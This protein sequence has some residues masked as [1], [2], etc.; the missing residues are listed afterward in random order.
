VNRRKNGKSPS[1]FNLRAAGRPRIAWEHRDY[2]PHRTRLEIPKGKP[3]HVVWRVN[4]HVPP[5]RRSPVLKV[6]R[7]AVLKARQWGLR[8]VH[9]SLMNDHLHLLIEAENKKDLGKSLQ[10]FAISF[11]KRLK[12][13][14]QLRKTPIF[15]ERY[16]CHI[17]RTV[18]EVKNALW[19]VL[20]NGKKAGLS[21]WRTDPYSS[22]AMLKLLVSDLPTIFQDKARNVFQDILAPPSF[23]IVKKSLCGVT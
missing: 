9:F 22:G 8:I 11:T 6:F 21:P 15:K 17:L 1:L 20:L 14:Y 18:Q 13:L 23:W 2:V 7:Q 19:Y 4:P 10:S 5:C 3:V 16:F 12:H